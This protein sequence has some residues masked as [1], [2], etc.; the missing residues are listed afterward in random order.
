MHSFISLYDYVLIIN[1]NMCFAEFL[2]SAGFMSIF[3]SKE[4]IK[5]RKKKDTCI[6]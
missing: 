4:V 5:Q 6:L 3:C 1:T 2:L